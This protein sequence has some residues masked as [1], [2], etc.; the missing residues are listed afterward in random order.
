MAT[1]NRFGIQPAAEL[2]LEEF[3]QAGIGPVLNEAAFEFRVAMSER[4]IHLWQT[5]RMQEQARLLSCHFGIDPA[6][7]IAKLNL[8]IA[9]WPAWL[10]PALDSAIFA[11][12]VA[13]LASPVICADTMKSEMY[14][15]N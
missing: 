14:L 9:A 8:E 15:P 3:H 2:D 5:A 7:L 1:E 10:S 11:E 12:F 4:K 6:V 13:G